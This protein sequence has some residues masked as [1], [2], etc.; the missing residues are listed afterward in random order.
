MLEGNVHPYAR[1]QFDNGAVAD[2]FPMKRMLLVLSRSEE[3]EKDLRQ[4][5]DDQQTADS[6]RFRQWLTPEQFG[7]MFGPADSDLQT[8]TSWLGSQGFHVDRVSNAKNIVEFS[9]NAKQVRQ[10]FHTQIH[11]YTVAG[12]VHFANPTN[13][14]IP[15]ALAPVVKGIASLNNFDRKANAHKFG[16]YR[17]DLSTGEVTPEFTIPTSSGSAYAIGPADFATIYNTQPLQQANITGTG[18]TIA[19][20][21]VSNVNLQDVTDFRNMFGLGAGNTSVEI[22]GDDPG[23]VQGAEFEALL[24]LEWANAAAPGASVV[25]V[26][27]AGTESSGALELAALHVIEK[28]TA[29]VMSV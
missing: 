9:G 28:N 1:A 18:Q 11:Q 7:K 24:D 19:V 2:A 17:R 27:S 12:K 13:P 3:Q 6:P 20:L 5:L 29:N 4:L 25:L 15:A 8:V 16:I 26:A 14:E 22:D 21:G 23:I 10:A